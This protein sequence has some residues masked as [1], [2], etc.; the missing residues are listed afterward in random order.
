MDPD[1]AFQ[2]VI[3]CELCETP[4]PPLFC[5]ICHIHLCKACIGEH[6][7]DESKFHIVIQIKHRQ[8][9]R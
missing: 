4:A 2:D 9:I 3:R 5:E 6:L 1:Y 8:S 7:L